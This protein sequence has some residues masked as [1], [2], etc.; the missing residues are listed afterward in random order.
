MICIDGDRKAWTTIFRREG[1]LPKP[2]Q[3]KQVHY[4]PVP[5]DAEINHWLAQFFLAIKT[6]NQVGLI[7]N[8]HQMYG[9]GDAPEDLA[10]TGQHLPVICRMYPGQLPQVAMGAVIIALVIAVE[11]FEGE[12]VVTAI[13]F[14]D[15]LGFRGDRQVAVTL[16]FKG[17]I[18]EKGRSFEF[19]IATPVACLDVDQWQQADSGNE[20][21]LKLAGAL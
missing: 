5:D 3:H 11:G 2:G 18:L 14:L 13:P 21:L 19:D 16:A 7:D 1:A 10:N 12:N 20:Q 4:T 17:R 8:V 9:F 15:V 6:F